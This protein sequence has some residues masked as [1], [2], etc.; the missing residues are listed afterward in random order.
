MLV[1]MV[2]DTHSFSLVM[3]TFLFRKLGMKFKLLLLQNWRIQRPIQNVFIWF[4]G[5]SID[6]LLWS[7]QLIPLTLT[8]SFLNIISLLEIIN[9]ILFLNK[10]PIGSPS[11]S[12]WVVAPFTVQSDNSSLIQIQFRS[13]WIQMETHVFFIIHLILSHFSILAELLNLIG[14]SCEI[15]LALF[16]ELGICRVGLSDLVSAQI[17]HWDFYVYHLHYRYE[18]LYWLDSN[19]R[20]FL[21]H[22]DFLN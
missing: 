14:D 10:K 18:N 17:Q 5:L 21:L 8:R 9:Q 16:G 3:R 6:L 1:C 22:A 13:W 11:P 20:R 12:G 19:F 2:L 15:F 4:I 7:I